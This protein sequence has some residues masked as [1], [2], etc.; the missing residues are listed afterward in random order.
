MIRQATLEAYR[1]HLQRRG[2]ARSTQRAYLAVARRFLAHLGRPAARLTARD[3]E[4]YLASRSGDLSPATQAH[5][6]DKLRAFMRGLVSLG[7]LHDDPAA[8]TS[9]RRASQGLP[10][11]LSE[12]AVSL[13]LTTASQVQAN[14]RHGGLPAALRD[15]ALLEVAYGLGL[16][17]SELAALKVVDL[18]LG[19]SA[20]RAHRAKRGGQAILPLPPSALEPLRR[21]LREGRPL[22]VARGRHRD[23]GHLL[24]TNAGSPMNG[25]RVAEVVRRVA[26]RAKLRAHPHAL[27][28]ALA[29]QL[30]AQG[31]SLTA[32]QELLGHA[33]LDTTARYIEV[34]RE[35]LHRTV[36]IIDRCR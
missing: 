30:I 7:L 21:Y 28:R 16:R 22:L 20:L 9:V 34:D 4:S 13:L 29:S 8:A 26:R 17:A 18:N 19:E 24:L 10:L 2:L 23:Q 14:H 15:R 35:S 5:E 11:L 36:A 33:R 1:G 31:A 6:H 32:V 25:D 3:L 12:E 27:R